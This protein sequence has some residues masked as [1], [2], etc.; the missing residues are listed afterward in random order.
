MREWRAWIW[1]RGI[2]QEKRHRLMIWGSVGCFLLLSLLAMAGDRGFLELR[3]FTR[4]LE[5]LEDRIR[6]LEEE[7]RQVRR[8]VVG[9]KSDPYQIERLARE[10]LKLARPDELIFVIVD[11]PATTV[12]KP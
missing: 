7:N 8:Q 10:D 11:A 5:D 2:G 9:L 4:H 12:N 3:E 6:N 1:V